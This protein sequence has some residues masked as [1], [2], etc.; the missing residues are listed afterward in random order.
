MAK[1]RSIF[2]DGFQSY[3][4]EGATFVGEAGIPMLMNL[5]N[6]QVPKDLLSFG[7]ARTC[8]N[9]RQYLNISNLTDVELKCNN[10]VVIHKPELLI[11]RDF[12]FV[13]AVFLSVSLDVYLRG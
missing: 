6:V 7:K 10:L 3:L 9:K 1:R 4:T 2:D 11:L 8:P 5:D 12:Q 13:K